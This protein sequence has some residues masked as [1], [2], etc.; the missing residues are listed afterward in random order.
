MEGNYPPKDGILHVQV[1]CCTQ[2]EGEGG[3]AAVGVVIPPHGQHTC[4][5]APAKRAARR[6]W[7]A[8]GGSGWKIGV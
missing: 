5:M 1:G 2:Q 7:E 4:I 3:A 8:S 6:G